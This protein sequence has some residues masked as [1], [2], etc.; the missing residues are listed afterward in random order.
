MK[1]NGLQAVVIDFKDD[2]GYLTYD[3]KLSLPQEMKAVRKQIKLEELVKRLH[4]DNIYLIAR[5]VVFKDKQLYNYQKNKYAIWDRVSDHPW[6][7]LVTS[8]DA[9]K[10]TITSVQKEFW[11]D[12]FCPEVWEY[13][14]SIAEELQTAGVDEI[15]FDYIRFPTDGDVSRIKCRFSPKGAEKSDALESFLALARRRLHIPISIDL[16]GFNC[17]YRMEE[18]TGQNLEIISN[19]VDVICPMFYPS[20]F[21]ER[22]LK[23]IPYLERA[24]KIYEDGTARAYAITGNKCI[25]RPYVQAFLIGGEVR[26]KPAEYS[27][28]LLNQLEGTYAV[29]S[30]GF[31]L[32]NNSGKYYMFT[33]TVKEY[34]RGLNNEETTF[35][36]QSNISY[37]FFNN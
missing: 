36:N 29:S 18:L 14:L 22:F 8:A 10:K 16:Y 34:L 13:N 30:A 9:E 11:V 23:D 15:Q 35:Y 21:T 32:W 20:H 28:Y 1:E 19:Y 12:P 33:K 2:F 24:K 7:H 6:R 25:I 31:T 37:S 4:E 3:T 17:W 26:M 27:R 5:L